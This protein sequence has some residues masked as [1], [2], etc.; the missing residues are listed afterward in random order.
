MRDTNDICVKKKNPSI[1][2]ESIHSRFS[3][4]RNVTLSNTTGDVI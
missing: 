2:P 4:F 1:L 3:F